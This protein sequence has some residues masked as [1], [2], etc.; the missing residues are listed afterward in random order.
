MS[1][2]NFIKENNKKLFESRL[3]IKNKDSL[4]A[5]KIYLEHKRKKINNISS[6]NSTQPLIKENFQEKLNNHSYLEKASWNINKSIINKSIK[7]N[8][9]QNQKLS[10]NNYFNKTNNSI[11]DNNNYFDKNNSLKYSNEKKNIFIN[12]LKRLTQHNSKNK[13]INS[14]KMYNIKKKINYK[15]SNSNKNNHKEI[16]KFNSMLKGNK[17]INENDSTTHSKNKNKNFN[18]NI[19]INNYNKNSKNNSTLK[20][21]YKYNSFLLENSKTIKNNKKL[22]LKNNNSILEYK[23]KGRN[24]KNHNNKLNRDKYIGCSQ[25]NLFNDNFGNLTKNTLGE[26]KF[27][28]NTLTY[29]NQN[30]TI[31]YENKVYKKNL[32]ENKKKKYYFNQLIL[33]EKN[34]D[35]ILINNNF[36]NINKKITYNLFKFDKKFG[37]INP[38]NANESMDNRANVIYKNYESNNNKKTYQGK[39]I[40]KNNKNNILY[41]NKEIIEYNRRLSEEINKEKNNNKKNESSLEENSGILS[42]N[43]IEDIICYN[44]MSNINKED[45]YLFYYKDHHKF[46]KK[47]KKTINNL[48]FVNPKQKKTYIQ[49]KIKIKKKLIDSK[50]NSE[51]KNTYKIKKILK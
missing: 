12:T 48:F 9:I 10:I 50:E 24:N 47:Y 3:Q 33:K 38:I 2:N 41:I 23:Y 44:N 45:N 19:H 46:L 7:N 21:D 13:S 25:K 15:I 6:R 8:K 4:N 43:E 35:K 20:K 28:Q 40:N 14:K 26:I 5:D 37:T 49:S 51:N 39:Q 30:N 29:K 22:N 36:N 34:K 11:K 27:N 42:I 16:I 1:T 32:N 31:N 18:K 17:I